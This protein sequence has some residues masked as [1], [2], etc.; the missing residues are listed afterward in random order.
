MLKLYPFS[1][2]SIPYTEESKKTFIKSDNQSTLTHF[3][4]ASYLSRCVDAKW[5]LMGNNPKNKTLKGLPCIVEPPRTEVE[6]G[7]QLWTE[8]FSRM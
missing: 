6:K 8:I 1:F 7:K 3:F 2:T 5:R 4:G